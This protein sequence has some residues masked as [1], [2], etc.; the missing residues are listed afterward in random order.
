MIVFQPLRL[1]EFVFVGFEKETLIPFIST[2][3]GMGF[4]NSG[5][6]RYLTNVKKS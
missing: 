5:C 6:I 1:I 4:L 3:K 2:M